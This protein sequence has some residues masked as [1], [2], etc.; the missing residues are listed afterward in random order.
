M[1]DFE[2][3]EK[4]DKVGGD[5]EGERAGVFT[6]SQLLFSRDSIR[7]KICLT[8]EAELIK[9]WES[10]SQHWLLSENP[11]PPKNYFGSFFF[12]RFSTYSDID[13]ADNK[14]C[15]PSTLRQIVLQLEEICA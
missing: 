6:F 13:C 11:P 3:E 5:A 9:T 15:V 7:G 8:M 2:V 10:F 14:S 1:V 12:R 4:R